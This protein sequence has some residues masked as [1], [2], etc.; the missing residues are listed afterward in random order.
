VAGGGGRNWRLVRADTDAVPSSVR[1]FMA[2]A[3]Q[4]RLRAALPW[5]IAAGVLLFAGGLAWVVY[6][7]SVLGV[8]QVRVVGAELVTPLQVEQAAAVRAD[9][10]L[11]GVDTDA[12]RDRVRGIPAVERVVIRRSWPSTLVIEVVERVPVAAVP[13]PGGEFT[14]IDR[15]GVPYRRV[16]QRPDGLPIV[17]LATPGVTD[18]NTKAALKVLGSLS[19]ELRGQL[20]AL[21]VPAPTQIRLELR[22][23]RT[24]VWGD[25]TEN[26]T[27]SEAATAL[28][29]KAREQIDVSAPTLVTIR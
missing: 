13:A 16:V 21:A 27:K 10:P 7:T 1:R 22:K 18:L 29:G 3:R 2:R 28:L 23:D 24:V 20:V 8:R 5:A 19:D 6:G 9:A 15:T 26:E 11:A 25:D 14:L 12:V 4:R 17:R